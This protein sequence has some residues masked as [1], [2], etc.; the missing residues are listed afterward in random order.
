MRLRSTKVIRIV[1]RIDFETNDPAE[2]YRKLREL[3]RVA[4]PKVSYETTD[5]WFDDNGEP[6]SEEQIS[7]IW[8]AVVKEEDERGIA[9]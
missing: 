6:L 4:D 5:D 3:F 7:D 8:Q 1:T 2:A 9:P